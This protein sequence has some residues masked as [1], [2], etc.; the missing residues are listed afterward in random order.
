MTLYPTA[1]AILVI[2]A[3]AVVMKSSAG[4][5]QEARPA[6][7]PE[8]SKPA[9][10]PAAA[11]KPTPARTPVQA[12]IQLQVQVVLARYQGEK[13]ISSS[14]YVLSVNAFDYGPYGPN[15]QLRMGARVPIPA[16]QATSPDAKAITSISP[17]NY[18]EIGTNIDCRARA[19]GDGTFDLSVSIEDKSVYAA[20]GD[21]VPAAAQGPVIRTY[22]SS[23]T[24]ILRDGQTR[25]FTAATDRVNG[26]TIRAEVTL[27]V[28]K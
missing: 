27:T 15:S 11:P 4:W 28:I 5:A 21:A 9:P 14:P 2:A 10:Q 25:Q 20:T 12:Q 17:V 7:P 1:R 3:L 26:E 6:G 8:Q 16:L 19:I 13:R 24:L 22:Q 23:N 18:E